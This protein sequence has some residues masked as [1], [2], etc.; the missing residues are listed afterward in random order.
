[1]ALA[2]R[3][4]QS[5]L[6]KRQRIIDAAWK[7]FTKH[8][9]D[10]T[11]TKAIATK[12]GIATGTLFLYAPD[13]IDLLA[14]LFHDRISRAVDDGFATLPTRAPLHAQL[15]HLFASFF[16]MYAEQPALSH[17]FVRQQMMASGPNADRINLLTVTFVARLQGLLT[18]AEQQGHLSGKTPSVML[19]QYL[20]GMYTM[21][22]MAWVLGY[23]TI[24]TA[25]DPMLKEAI[26]LLL[27]GA[28]K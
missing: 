5:K 1:M 10:A 19:A 2:S 24:D 13:K 14:L 12:A 7:L 3:R 22:L 28:A 26:A 6:D 21:S 17:Q 11:T 25:V 4:Q 15:M 8:G 23:A 18:V 9:F 20:F 27:R 16:R